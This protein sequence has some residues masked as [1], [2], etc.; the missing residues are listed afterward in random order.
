[1]HP[2]I[3][4]Y[5]SKGSIALIELTPIFIRTQVKTH[6]MEP[7]PE[8]NQSMSVGPFKITPFPMDHSAPFSVA[9]LVEAGGK[10]V[11]Y[12]GDLRGH[13]RQ[14]YFFKDMIDKTPASIHGCDRLIL[15]GTIVGR[16][17]A[18][19]AT[20]LDVENALVDMLIKKQSLALLYC[21][22]QN[23]DRIVSAYEAALKTDSI[24]VIDFYTAYLLESLK[25]CSK[26]IPQYNSKNVRVFTSKKHEESLKRAGKE[27]FHKKVRRKS[28]IGIKEIVEKRKKVL[29]IDKGGLV[30][31]AIE[32]YF[33]DKDGIE[34]I[35][36]MWGGYRTGI[37][38]A[39]LFAKKHGLKITD[40]HTSGHASHADLKKLVDA[41]EPKWLIPIHT[42]DPRGFKNIYD[43]VFYCKDGENYTI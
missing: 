17:S 42:L 31:P 23:I 3:P 10:R 24:F 27:E 29:M 2:D 26:D 28:I 5:A 33:P 1:V 30:I 13:G 16:S 6:R 22:S 9:F 40:I 41:I 11:F 12:S 38:P 7:L 37:D 35:Y 14:S 32:K 21:S 39:S 43:K 19:Y 15:E 18:G 20:E 36:S 25:E 8:H 34:I 4:V